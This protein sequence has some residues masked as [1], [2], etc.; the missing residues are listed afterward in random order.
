MLDYLKRLIG[1]GTDTGPHESKGVVVLVIAVIWAAWTYFTG[2]QS[3]DPDV[4]S[5]ATERAGELLAYGA[6]IAAVLRVVSAFVKPF[7]KRE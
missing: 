5:Q 2:G 6:Q 1:F 4:A 3:L 7:L